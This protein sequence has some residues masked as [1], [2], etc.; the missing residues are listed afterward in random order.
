MDELE[1]VMLLMKTLAVQLVELDPSELE[2][3]FSDLGTVLTPTTVWSTIP[4]CKCL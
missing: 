4:K 2:D 1:K 3:T